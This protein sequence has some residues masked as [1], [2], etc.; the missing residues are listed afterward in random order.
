MVKGLLLIILILTAQFM[1]T[2]ASATDQLWPLQTK[3]WAEADK[4]DNLGHQW[5]VR[6]DVLEEVNLD[7]KNYFHI[8]EL[9]YDPGEWD[10]LNDVYIRSTDTELYLYNGPG[11]GE[12]LAFKLGPV[13]TNWIYDG[14]AK[15]KEVVAIENITIP[16][17]G[18]YTAYKFKQSRL[19]DPSRYLFEWVVPGLP[20]IAK[21]E[22]HWVASERIPLISGLARLGMNPGGVLGDINSDN[23]I[24]LIE[25]IYALQIVANNRQQIGIDVGGSWTWIEEQTEIFGGSCH[26]IG[27]TQTYSMMIDQNGNQLTL[28]S[29]SIAGI[30]SASITG[31]IT[32]YSVSLS[33]YICFNDGSTVHV[34]SKLIVSIDGRH[35]NGTLSQ[36]SDNLNYC[37]GTFKISA[38]KSP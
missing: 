23:R 7:G 31:S 24:D 21:E 25:A 13:G 14:G 28:T 15:K 18:P 9:C 29:D 3:L 16:Y 11:L 8:R 12:A 37:T 26:D 38:E 17:G 35:M 36:D 1:P 6:I 5:T 32:A 20:W 4:M 34:I 2:A 22:D 27:E 10:V 19:S 33:G 30:T